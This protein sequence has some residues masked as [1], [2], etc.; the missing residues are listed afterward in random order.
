MPSKTALAVACLFTKLLLLAGCAATTTVNDSVLPRAAGNEEQQQLEYWHEV[1]TKPLIS[2]DDAFH[3]LLLYIDGKDDATAYDQR[4]ATLKSRGFLPKNFDRP[5]NAALERGT[6]AV[7]LAKHLNLRGGLTMRLTGVTPRYATRELEYRGVYPPSS[8]QQIFTGGEFVGVIGK[9]EDFRRGDP[10]NLPAAA[11]P[12]AVAAAKKQQ[13]DDAELTHPIFAMILQAPN[14]LTLQSPAT[15]PATTQAAGALRIVITAVDGLASVRENENGAWKPAKVGMELT[16]DAEFR[17][18]PRGTIQFQIPP[19]QIVSVDRLTT[20]KVLTVLQQ[21]GK[22]TTDLGIKYGRTRYD[23]EGG[24]LEH[25]S[26]LRSPNATLAVRGTRVSL[27]D[28][29]PFAPQA[30]SLTGRAEFAAHRRKP[31]AFGAAGQGKTIVN[32]DSE[33]AGDVAL[34]STVIDPTLAGARTESELPLLTTVISRGATTEIDPSSGIR[35]VRGGIP[36]TDAQLAGNLPGRLSFVL[37]W[38]ADADLNLGVSTPNTDT[39]VGGEVVMPVAGLNVAPSGG[40]TAF[41]HR[42]GPAGGIEVVYF[43]S[44]PDGL[45]SIGGMNLSQ[46]TVTATIDAFLD[47]EKLD[48]FDGTQITKTVTQTVAPNQPALALA[49]VNTPLPFVEPPPPVPDL[50]PLPPDFPE[51]QSRP[52]RA[53]KKARTIGFSGN[54]VIMGPTPPPA[55]VTK[56]R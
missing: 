15:A 20:L 9:A 10:T 44:F 54:G 1:A 51:P 25:Q 34:A 30:I 37:R 7:A 27:F 52:D 56:R 24:G 11:P 36:P 19:N 28:Q 39:T 18:G 6:L 29:P 14:E 12:E 23:L 26:T 21:G 16:Q 49:G 42:G 33:T 38:N 40:R 5:A 50:P 8:P 45:Y 17:T 35:I 31:I 48:L 41:D 2:N 32:A 4:V 53:A 47:G 22:V 46:T 55:K 43:D 13:T 3:G